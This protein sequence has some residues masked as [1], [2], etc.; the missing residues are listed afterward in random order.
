M[1]AI[2]SYYVYLRPVHCFNTVQDGDETGLNVGGSCGGMPPEAD[3]QITQPQ[4]YCEDAILD[5]SASGSPD[6]A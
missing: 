6:P 5:G 1:Y 4:H 3:L 2:R